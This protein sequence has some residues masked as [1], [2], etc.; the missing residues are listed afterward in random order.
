MSTYTYAYPPPPHVRTDIL[1]SGLD[2]R[3]MIS[4]LQPPNT[5]VL[6]LT[7]IATPHRGSAFA[8]YM[9]RWIGWTNIPKIYKALNAFGF[10]TDAFHQLTMEY[11]K[12]FNEKVQD[13]PGVRY[14]SY[15]ASLRPH[16]SSVFRKSHQVRAVTRAA[17]RYPCLRR[18][19]SSRR[20]K[21]PMM[22]WSVFGVPSG[23]RTRARWT[24]SA[25]SI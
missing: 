4:R 22:G 12:G 3:Y 2:A 9:F 7:T 8:D 24:M 11:M 23:A 25:T 1:S 16:F 17:D 6:S 10:E 18:S 19:R 14:Y 20:W 15:G 5:K 21:V 13:V